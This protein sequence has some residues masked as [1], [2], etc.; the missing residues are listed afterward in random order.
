VK[1]SRW[2]KDFVG[3]SAFPKCHFMAK[4]VDPEHPF[5]HLEEEAAKPE[6]DK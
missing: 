6:K 2:G 1:K 3:C 5:D 4:I